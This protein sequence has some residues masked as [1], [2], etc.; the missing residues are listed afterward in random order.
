MDKKLNPEADNKALE[1]KP[2]NSDEPVDPLSSDGD[3]PLTDPATA[4]FIKGELD[5][6]DVI[7]RYE[8]NTPDTDQENDVDDLLHR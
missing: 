8:R 7:H 5:P 2:G 1:K 4:A 6:D 3:D